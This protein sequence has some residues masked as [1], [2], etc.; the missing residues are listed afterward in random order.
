MLACRI[1]TAAN[2]SVNQCF[3]PSCACLAQR[4][5]VCSKAVNV[6]LDDIAAKNSSDYGLDC[7]V[8]TNSGAGN[9]LQRGRRKSAHEGLVHIA[10]KGAAR[11]S[12]SHGFSSNGPIL[13]SVKQSVTNFCTVNFE[14]QIVLITFADGAGLQLAF[15]CTHLVQ[16]PNRWSVCSNKPTGSFAFGAPAPAARDL[17]SPADRSEKCHSTFLA[18]PVHNSCSC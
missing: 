2:K 15:L 17:L 14:K 4:V 18:W 6:V 10:R 9:D 16:P 1:H 12:G 3:L 8:P 5:I 13:V 11:W 7:V